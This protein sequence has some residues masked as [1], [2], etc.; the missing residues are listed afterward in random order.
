[1]T[2][3][4][5][6]QYKNLAIKFGIAKWYLTLWKNIA[7]IGVKRKEFMPMSYNSAETDGRFQ[8]NNDDECIMIRNR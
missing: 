1:M 4:I 7:G 2:K 6:V 8:V 5:Y 3:Y